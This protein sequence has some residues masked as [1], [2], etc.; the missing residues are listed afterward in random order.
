MGINLA[1]LSDLCNCL[2]LV[3]DRYTQHS[4]QALL[5]TSDL[6]KL[7]GNSEPI[8]G[9]NLVFITFLLGE[10]NNFKLD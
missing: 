1:I 10:F 4:S 6:F 7:S 8:Q 9:L 3:N 2:S 5:F